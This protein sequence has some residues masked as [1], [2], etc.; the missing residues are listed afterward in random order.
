MEDVMDE[1]AGEANVF[2]TPIATALRAKQ[3]PLHAQE[4][5]YTNLLTGDEELDQDDVYALISKS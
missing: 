2:Q 1:E 3:T 5:K 4:E